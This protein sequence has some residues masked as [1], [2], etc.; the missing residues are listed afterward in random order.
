[1]CRH[2]N[3]VWSIGDEAVVCVD[4]ELDGEGKSCI[5]T[6]HKTLDHFIAT[7][8]RYGRFDIRLSFKGDG[9]SH[10]LFEQAGTALGLAISS[11]L[12]NRS[13]LKQITRSTIPMDEALAD[14]VIDLNSG[15]GRFKYQSHSCIIDT[16]AYHDG[17]EIFC[18]L[19]FLE[20][21]VHNAQIN[22]HIIMLSAD[23]HHH[24]IEVLYKA[25]S[26]AIYEASR[27]VDNPIPRLTK[28]LT[29][30]DEKSSFLKDFSTQN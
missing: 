25:I 26:V 12:G 27:E 3:L 28:N 15:S 24:G 30:N 10:H 8:A 21:L 29:T 14:V 7:F 18:Y 16:A 9:I 1:M 13:K 4:F 5:D 17:V 6:G 2:S 20:K 22:L 19:H 11:A 23:D